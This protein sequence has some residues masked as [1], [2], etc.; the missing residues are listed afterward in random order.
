[1]P[2]VAEPVPISVSVLAAVRYSVSVTN[3]SLS[4]SSVPN[5]A[6]KSVS[7]APSA[8]LI[9]PSP[10]VSRR[11]HRS[12]WTIDECEAACSAPW[13]CGGDG[14]G[15]EC[16][17]CSVCSVA[18]LLTSC[19]VRSGALLRRRVVHGLVD[20]LTRFGLGPSRRRQQQRRHG[21]G[22]QIAVVGV[23]GFS[24]FCIL[25]RTVLLWPAHKRAAPSN[26]CGSG[27][28]SL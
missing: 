18:P 19:G 6:L 2:P 3:P 11:V 10:L 21:D 23:H 5:S 9:L 4:A 8:V 1:M 24:P 16:S 7:T 28:Y 15:V 26:A 14:G 13:D 12:R 22:E 27:L 20:G 17:I 25:R